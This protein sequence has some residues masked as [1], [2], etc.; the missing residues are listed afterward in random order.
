M[1]IDELVAKEMSYGI[2]NLSC[3]L[4]LVSDLIS[5]LLNV[6]YKKQAGSGNVNFKKV[7]VSASG[8]WK[9]TVAIDAQSKTLHTEDE[10]TYTMIHVPQQECPEKAAF[11]HLQFALNEK[12]NIAI[13]LLENTTL[14]F[15]A[16]FLTH[17]HTI[18]DCPQHSKKSFVSFGSYGNRKLLSHLRNSYSRVKEQEKSNK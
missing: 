11:H 9:I 15:S 10:C 18:Q 1:I 5:P 2:Q 14:M 13:P 3:H 12:N 16:Q 17:R 8:L 7:P 6:T 4:P